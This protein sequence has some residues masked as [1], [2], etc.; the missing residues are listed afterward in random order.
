M[1]PARVAGDLLETRSWEAGGPARAPAH[2]ATASDRPRPGPRGG[3]AHQPPRHTPPTSTRG[4]PLLADQTQ[5]PAWSE[6]PPSPKGL[7]PQGE[8][9]GPGPDGPPTGVCPCRGPGPRL[10]PAA[11]ECTASPSG[12]V[13]GVRGAHRMV[14]S[15]SSPRA[16]YV[17]K[18]RKVPRPP[19]RGTSRTPPPPQTRA[20]PQRSP[21]S[22]GGPPTAGQPLLPVTG[23]R[24]PPPT[25]ALCPAGETAWP[26]AECPP[27]GPAAPLSPPR[28]ALSWPRL[29]QALHI[30]R[31]PP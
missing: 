25:P 3:R 6:E 7:G 12:L 22:G 29:L 13:P 18:G 21:S 26:P 27:A 31:A 23:E 20:S 2:W 5:W 8:G 10:P 14:L 17:G 4:A 28:A 9:A 15:L 19:S 24:T 11:W 30:S 1:A 16:A